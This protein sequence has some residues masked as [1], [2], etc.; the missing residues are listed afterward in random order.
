MQTTSGYLASV[1]VEAYPSGARLRGGLNATGDVWLATGR[2]LP[3]TTYQMTYKVDGANG[4]TTVGFG[5]F[6]T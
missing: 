2:L 3:S 5:T 6:S 4:V 1:M